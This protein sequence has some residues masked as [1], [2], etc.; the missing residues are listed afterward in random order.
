MVFSLAGYDPFTGQTAGGLGAPGYFDYVTKGQML[1]YQFIP[2]VAI[3]PG[4]YANKKV[5]RALQGGGTA[6]QDNLTVVQALLDTVGVK[7]KPA[8]LKKLKN[9]KMAELGRQLE[10]LQ[11]QESALYQK[12][13]KILTKIF[14]N[15][16]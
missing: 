6:Y 16:F 9:R 4:T 12:Y 7:L 3:I 1:A 5:V 14:Q 15:L 13:L 2:N 10:A 11:Q 8:E